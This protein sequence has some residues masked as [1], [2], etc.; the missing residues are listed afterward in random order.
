MICAYV[1]LLTA[2][3]QTAGSG[4]SS[5]SSTSTSTKK[6]TPAPT[7]E[8]TSTSTSTPPPDK[9]D[10]TS[11][12]GDKHD[13]KSS[14]IISRPFEVPGLLI[15]VVLA[16]V[17]CQV[18]LIVVFYGIRKDMGEMED[19]ARRVAVE[20][21]EPL[22]GALANVEARMASLREDIVGIRQSQEPI[23]ALAVNRLASASQFPFAPQVGNVTPAGG[24]YAGGT[25]VQIQ[26]RN[27]SPDAQVWFGGTSAQV[28]PTSNTIQ[29][30]VVAPPGGPGD[31]DIYIVNPNGMMSQQRSVRYRYADFLL[32]DI[33]APAAG[34]LHLSGAGFSPQTQVLVDGNAAPGATLTNDRTI[35]V[36]VP[37]GLA[38]GIHRVLLMN[39]GG[40]LTQEKTFQS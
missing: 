10:E 22:T 6:K 18:V 32:D 4:Q 29:L 19:T 34:R 12:S 33:P 17:I 21:V 35:E 16:V 9:P 25:R 39:P 7:S 2:L 28:L 15:F 8:S 3:M 30:D 11:K 1:L 36:A 40:D 38:A 23:L 20:S 5:S 31:V 26:G 14:M 24:K 13:D 27:F 37:A